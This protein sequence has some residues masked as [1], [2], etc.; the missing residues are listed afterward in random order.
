M[1]LLR[2]ERD[3]NLSVKREER[4]TTVI[5]QQEKNEWKTYMENQRKEYVS[6]NLDS[7]FLK[8]HFLTIYHEY[9][10]ISGF[11]AVIYLKQGIESHEIV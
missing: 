2:E 11:A 3:E 10:Q 4:L 9:M 6:N 7:N 1:N 5:L 8:I